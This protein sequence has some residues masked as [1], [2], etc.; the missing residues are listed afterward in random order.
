MNDNQ[1]SIDRYLLGEMD[2]D[3]SAAFEKRLAGDSVLFEETELTRH[4]IGAIRVEGEQ[5]AINA[6]KS[7]PEEIFR[8][9]IEAPQPAVGQSEEVV[10]GR[11][12][13]EEAVGGS[14]Q[15]EKAVGGSGQVDAG[16]L[17]HRRRAFGG[18]SRRRVYLW[19][20]AAAAVVFIFLLYTGTRPRHTAE[21]L[22]SQY[23]RVQTY[24]T[25]PVRGGFDLS[26]DE[27]EWI[28][29]AET[30]YRRADY[31]AAL[32]FYNRLLT[33]RKDRKMLPEEVLFYS[34]ICRLATDDLPGAIEALE[35]ISSDETFVFRDDA[36]WNLTFA[37]LKSGQRT[38]A[39]ACL[40]RLAAGDSDYA[41][42]ARTLSDKIKE[43]KWF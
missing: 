4:I 30:C 19:L 27:R 11:G 42:K 33:E 21:Q 8:K 43:K 6:M 41:G 13:S 35:Y 37:F 38:K 22:F 9:W 39:S 23:Y 20:S 16:N 10:G 28:R 29:Q 32:S 31:A 36:L 17:G 18:G 25:H 26:L 1:E 5:A 14:G 24:E 7:I 3:E 40:E 15:A 12:Q 2:G 34:A